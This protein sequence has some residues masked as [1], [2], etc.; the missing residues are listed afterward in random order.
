MPRRALVLSVSIVL[1]LTAT[2]YMFSSYT[3]DVGAHEQRVTGHSDIIQTE[4]GQLEYATAGNG[5]PVLM[6]HGTGGGFDQGLT[7]TEGLL[8]HGYRI[9][10]PSRFGYLRSS[11]PSD[12]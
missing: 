11:F 6:I 3:S 2:V 10:A 1:V 4:Y 12:A 7:F 5:S 8:P 9:I